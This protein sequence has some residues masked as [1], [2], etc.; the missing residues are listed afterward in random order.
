MLIFFVKKRPQCR[1]LV[2][3]GRI[4][5]W[6]ETRA[7]R[8]NNCLMRYG[9]AEGRFVR[10]QFEGIVRFSFNTAASGYMIGALMRPYRRLPTGRRSDGVRPYLSHL[11]EIAWYS[12]V[13]RARCNHWSTY[14]HITARQQGRRII[15]RQVALE[16]WPFSRVTT[17]RPAAEKRSTSQ[18]RNS[19]CLHQERCGEPA[20]VKCPFA[21]SCMQ[22][23]P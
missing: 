18:T 17:P 10:G 16:H 12:P 7:L 19:Y 11:S 4:T 8:C 6:S 13:A 1:S 2:D 14:C 20:P 23:G 9:K 15:A 21:L 22:R 5:N 3:L